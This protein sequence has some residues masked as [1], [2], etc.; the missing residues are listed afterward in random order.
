MLLARSRRLRAKAAWLWQSSA[1]VR[2]EGQRL[3][4][5][6]DALIQSEPCYRQEPERRLVEDAYCDVNV[7]DVQDLRATQ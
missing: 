2:T 6:S 3:C 7:D 5:A 4:Q 1:Q